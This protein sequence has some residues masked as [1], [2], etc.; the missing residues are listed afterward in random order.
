LLA[1]ETE[2]GVG[3][4]GEEGREA[5][6]VAD[7]GEQRGGRVDALAE[8]GD[9]GG[10]DCLS[11]GRF[12]DLPVVAGGAGPVECLVREGVREIEP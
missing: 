2:R 1:A 4:G 12:G 11:A 3:G 6:D 7:I 8:I 10:R 5:M 9:V